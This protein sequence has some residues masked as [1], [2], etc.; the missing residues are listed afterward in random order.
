M[1]FWLIPTFL[2]SLAILK[3]VAVVVS[4]EGDKVGSSFEYELGLG[5]LM[6]KN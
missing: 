4:V 6:V 2:I 1:H 5:K 3:E